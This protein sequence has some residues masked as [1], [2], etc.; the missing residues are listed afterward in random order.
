[1]KSIRIEFIET[2]EKVSIWMFLGCI[3]IAVGCMIPDAVMPASEFNA[4]LFLFANVSMIVLCLLWFM[5][6]SICYLVRKQ[7]ER[8]QDTVQ[9]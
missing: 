2:V 9:A 5:S 8:S 7:L 6:Q 1:M 4:W 3:L